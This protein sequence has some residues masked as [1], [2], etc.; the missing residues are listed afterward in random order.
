[1][2]V[3]DDFLSEY[4]FKQLDTQ[5][6]SNNLFPWY[7]NDGI[8]DS[9]DGKGYQF[10]HRVFDVRKGGVTSDVFPFFEPVLEKLNVKRLDRIKLNLNPPT[11]FHRGGGWHTDNYP[12]DP[13][14]HTKT[15]VFYLN[16]NN[17]WT[18]FKKSG[19]VKSKSNRIVIFDSSLEH[20]GVTCTNENRRVIVNFNYDI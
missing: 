9:K 17:G 15:A 18:E 13:F 7:Y 6:L 16:T 8:L 2:E 11:F 1:M 12:T 10:T 5:I 4:Q 14:Q 3:C 20:Q 19:K